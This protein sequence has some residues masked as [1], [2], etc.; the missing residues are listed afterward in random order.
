[1]TG[2]PLVR[3]ERFPVATPS[4]LPARLTVTPLGRSGLLGRTVAGGL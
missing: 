2:R 3:V 1:M 4:G